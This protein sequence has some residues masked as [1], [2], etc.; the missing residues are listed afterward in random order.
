MLQLGPGS[1]AFLPEHEGLRKEPGKGIF[2][3]QKL[4]VIRGIWKDQDQLVGKEGLEDTAG[5][6]RSGP[7]KSQLQTSLRDSPD[8]IDAV[9]DMEAELE[10]GGKPVELPQHVRKD[11]DTGDGGG[12][13]LQ[14]AGALRRD[15]MQGLFP[16]LQDP[17]GIGEEPAAVSGQL[18]ALCGAVDEPDVQ[19]LFQ[20]PDMGA[21]G[22]L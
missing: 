19:L 9:G 6:L 1:G 8:D 2:L 10:I 3:L 21:D 7:H 14:D 11:M 13:D 5:V 17:L 4:L 22:R 15:L 16:K 12:T 20:G 18:K